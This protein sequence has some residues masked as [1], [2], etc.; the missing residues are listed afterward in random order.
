MFRTIDDFQRSWE[1]TQ[2]DTLKIFD[3]L[4]NESLSQSVADGHRTIGRI[5]WHI[6]QTIPEMM[7]LTGLKISGPDETT[8]P[9]T[10][11]ATIR[12]TYAETASTFLK[13]VTDKWSDDTLLQT[14]ELYGETWPRGL[15][16]MIIIVHEVH[17]RGQLTVLMRQAGLTVPGVFGPAKEEW[18]AFGAPVPAI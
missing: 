5:A 13:E 6:V 10:N 12:K 18:A 1:Q 8:P 17:H 2:N 4:T 15:T 7:G 16:L 9:P 11:A 14:D 3:A